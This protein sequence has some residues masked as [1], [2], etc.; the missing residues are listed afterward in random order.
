MNMYVATIISSVM[1]IIG[2]YIF[3]KFFVFKDKK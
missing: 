3:S 1:V 2:N